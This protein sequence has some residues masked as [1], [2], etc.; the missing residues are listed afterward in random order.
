MWQTYAKMKNEDAHSAQI[1]L[2]HAVKHTSRR[3]LV[4]IRITNGIRREPAI[5][6]P[7]GDDA[8]HLACA[9]LHI[10]HLEQVAVHTGPHHFVAAGHI[11]SHDRHAGTQ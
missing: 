9:I 4:E 11:R 1:A 10:P 6:R 7:F 5:A 3:E 8:F 2:L